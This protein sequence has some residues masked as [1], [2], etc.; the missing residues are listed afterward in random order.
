MFLGNKVRRVRKADKLTA[1]YEPSTGGSPG[2]SISRQAAHLAPAYLRQ[3]QAT[4]DHAHQ[5]VLA[6]WP[7]VSTLYP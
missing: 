7:Q 1:I 6:T 5:N 4:R 2:A 3:A